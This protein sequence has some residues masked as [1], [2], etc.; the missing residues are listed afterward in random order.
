MV[1][2]R[3]SPTIDSI[4]VF[5]PRMAVEGGMGWMGNGGIGCQFGI[6]VSGYG[7]AMVS[8]PWTEGG[9]EVFVCNGISRVSLLLQ[10]A[11][12]RLGGALFQEGMDQGC[13]RA[14]Y[15]STL[16]ERGYPHTSSN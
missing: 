6:I 1:Y 7:I 8:L 14:L 13:Y 15:T 3:M 16:E 5:C 9:A 2:S 12:C 10:H 11:R 4:Q